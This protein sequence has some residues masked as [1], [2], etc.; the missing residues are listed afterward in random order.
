VFNS[1]SVASALE[2]I[3]DGTARPNYSQN[4]LERTVHVG[5]VYV[6]IS[7]LAHVIP[8]SKCDA[9]PNAR[10]DRRTSVHNRPGH[11]GSDRCDIL[12]I[13]ERVEGR[14]C[15]LGGG[16]AVCERGAVGLMGSHI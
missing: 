10:I 5:H 16:E 14:S 2:S 9:T 7:S 8:V 15:G 6:Y 12:G 4:M 11:P 3:L 13:E 1:I